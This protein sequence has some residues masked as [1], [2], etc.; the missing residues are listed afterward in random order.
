MNR[1]WYYQYIMIK[2]G[3]FLFIFF[4]IVYVFIVEN[5]RREVVWF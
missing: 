2:F 3:L 1:G 4:N 5:L